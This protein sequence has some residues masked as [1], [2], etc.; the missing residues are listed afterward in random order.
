[1]QCAILESSHFPT[2]QVEDKW[3]SSGTLQSSAVQ[4]AVCGDGGH[5]SVLSRQVALDRNPHWLSMSAEG[6][7]ENTAWMHVSGELGLL[8][9]CGRSL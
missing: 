1:M 7:A 3:A 4:G 8:I 5:R 2:F 9:A 6:K